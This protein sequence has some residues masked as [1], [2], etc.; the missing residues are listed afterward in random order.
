MDG[1][2]MVPVLSS[3]SVLNQPDAISHLSSMQAEASR[4]SPHISDVSDILFAQSVFTSVNIWLS[5]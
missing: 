3:L 2:T 5:S 1:S 4:W